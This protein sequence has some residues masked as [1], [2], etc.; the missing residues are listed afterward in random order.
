MSWRKY[1]TPV[2]TSG[3][4]S[5]IS[6]SM[7]SNS[8]NPSRTNYSS[9][10][11]DVYAGHPNRLERYGQYDTMDSDSEVNAALDI[12]AEFCTQPSEEN[13]TP[14][15]VFFKDQAT[16][17]EIK[18]IKKY[19]QQW[20]KLNKFNIRIFKI[21]RNAFKYGDSFF[22]RDPE[23][24]SWMYVDPAKVDKIIVNESEGKKPEQYHIR[25][26]NPNFETLATTAIQPSNTR[27]GG[28]SF[29]G[30]YGT[31]QGGAGGS[32]GMVGSSPTSTNSSRF[33]LNQNQYAIDAR[34]VIHLSMSEGLDN[35]FPFGNSL[36]ES[37]FKVFKQKE[38][39]EDAILI[40]RI[41]RA[42]ERRVFY[43]DV[44]NMPSHLAMSFV[45]RVKNEVNQRRIPSTTGGSQSVV[46]AS[47]NPL[48]LDLDT[49][50]PLLDG[51]TLML[52]EIIQEFE[53][54]KENW[55][56]SCNPG[57]GEIVP[58]VINWAGV[59]R[60]NTKVIKL[61]LDNGKELICTPD[62]KIPVFG[63]GF[64]QAQD[65]T[66]HDSL[67]AFNTRESNMPNSKNTYQQVWDHA[68][69]SWKWTHRVVGE[70]FRNMGKH[71]E[72][73]YLPENTNK[74]KAVIHHRDS[75]RYN[76]DPRNLTYMNREDHILYHA[77]QKKD[78]WD[79][80]TDAYR[81]C[82]TSKISNTLKL[83]WVNMT[84]TQRLEALW[85]IRAA[86]RQAVY[87]R[88]HDPLVGAS[89][90]K[91]ASASRKKYLNDHP[92]VQDQL[93]RNLESRVK[94]KNQTLNLT[95]DMLQ[96]VSDKVKS[97]HKNKNQ[98]IALCD[99]DQELLNLVRHANSQ[100]LDYGNAQCKIDFDRFGYNKLDRLIN[101]F[102][103]K[104]WKTFVREIDNFNH[105]IVKIES[106]S[107]RDTGTIT[108]DGA[109][110]WHGFH[111]FAI[112]SGIFVKNSVNEDYF[113]PQTAEGRGSKVEILQGGQN[114]GE[115]DDLKYF[116]NKLFRALRIP[117]SY[118]P[119]G[120][121]DGGSNFNDGRVGT[122]YIQELRFNK[123]CE[124]LQSLINEPFDLEFKMYLHAKGINID[125][126]IFDLKFNPPQNF[127]AYRQT[128]MDTARVTT[129]TTMMV[130][131]HISKRFAL[132]RFLGLTAEELAENETLWREEN[133]DTD[134]NLS[135]SVELRNAGIT[136]NGITGDLSGL[137]TTTQ[138]PALEPGAEGQGMEAGGT[139]GA[140]SPTPPAA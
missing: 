107:D 122:A 125:S 119:T 114:L 59:T 7:G 30:S 90:A 52:S 106:V 82:M 138:P 92:E 123:Y 98:V 115:I 67:I 127:A 87:M 129:Y 133:V 25:D 118:L 42:P 64:I 37:I 120:S 99:H 60:K 41:Q 56:Y 5:P 69:K 63:K 97:G 128:E 79:T 130:V 28:S 72:F 19:L 50:I 103:Y 4:L 54:G 24:Q 75:N 43:I 136:A 34:H 108:I 53:S 18:I 20:T 16:S 32:R 135:A 112:D 22:V 39:L 131:P 36:L 77:S 126:N 81:D 9:Y 83:R 51:R 23:T 49:R 33:S 86:Q 104:N 140:A 113:F 61:T 21:V 132:K 91:N 27:G 29:G 137:S 11:P 66:I 46:D 74:P 8:G 62:H 40:Y 93:R 31:G 109:E 101:M 85:N 80:M 70:F 47:Y 117:S 73:T 121:D 3:K 110:R 44:G 94:I 15:Q 105:R 26:F 88:K 17:T 84:E 35:N 124:R 68:S 13:G 102:G 12:L 45:E 78:F 139:P 95:F 71:Q 96:I 65:L 58:G 2:E 111:T 116:T 38:L 6:G 89:Y 1:F 100:P 134:T 76:N 55:A 10:L 57:T 14:F 48:C